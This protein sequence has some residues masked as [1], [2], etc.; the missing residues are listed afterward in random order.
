MQTD[1]PFD[2]NKRKF[3]SAGSHAS[4]FI[5][6]LIASIAIPIAILFVSEDPVVKDN[7]KE[8]INFH[9][10]VWLLGGLIAV[11]SFLTLGLFGFIF[12]P[13]WLLYHWGLTIWAIIHCL[14]EPESAFRYPFILRLL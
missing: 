11:F 10:N 4:I 12:G 8:A 2:P 5:S 9:L 3:L 1:S 14:N 7:A 13:L 6:A